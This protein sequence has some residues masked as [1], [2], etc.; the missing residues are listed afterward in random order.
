MIRLLDKMKKQNKN[1]KNI[2]ISVDPPKDTCDDK[3]CPFHG[4]L[5]L[6][7]RTFT[8]TIVN[9]DVHRSATIEF[10]KRRHIPKYER[11]EVRRTKLRVHNPPCI[12]AE[13]GEIVMV[14]ESRPLSKT[15][16]FVIIKRQGEDLRYKEKEALIAEDLAKEPKEKTP[17]TNNPEKSENLK[18]T[19]KMINKSKKNEAEK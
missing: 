9:K 19:E 12:N 4:N 13:E 3:K 10:K 18:E 8:G 6:R 16:N 1:Q 5:K 11:Y 7:G 17:N 14:A 2:G 15:K